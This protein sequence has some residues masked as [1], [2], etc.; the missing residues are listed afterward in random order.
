[1]IINFNYVLKKEFNS[2][3]IY[4]YRGIVKGL[5]GWG[6]NIIRGLNFIEDYIKVIE[7]NLG[8]VDVYYNWV[9]VYY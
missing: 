7:L 4:F 5:L 6:W 1:M 3:E 2:L 9:N 8:Y